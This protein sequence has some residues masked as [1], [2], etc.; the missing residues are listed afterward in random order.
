MTD[1]VRPI[2]PVRGRDRRDAQRRSTERRAE[3]ETARAV[4]RVTETIEDPKDD[5]VTP[6]DPARPAASLGPEA[7][8]AAQLIGQGGQRTGIR[9]GPP[10]M[11]AARSSYLGNEYSGGKDRRPPLGKTGKTEA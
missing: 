7:A 11:G 9:G 10:V 4:V 6:H 5:P 2:D 3:T 8:F 1:G